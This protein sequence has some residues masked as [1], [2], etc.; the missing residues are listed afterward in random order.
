MVALRR[1]GVYFQHGLVH[2]AVSNLK[3]GMGYAQVLKTLATFGLA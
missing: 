1:S 2:H 3:P